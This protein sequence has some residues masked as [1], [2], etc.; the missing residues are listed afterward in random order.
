[1]LKRKFLQDLRELMKSFAVLRT[2]KTHINLVTNEGEATD[3]Q[4]TAEMNDWIEKNPVFTKED[5]ECLKIIF[6]K[7]NLPKLFW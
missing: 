6:R 1:M 4:F 7:H 5:I 3:E 2:V